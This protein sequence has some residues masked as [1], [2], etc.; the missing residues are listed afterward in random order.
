[1]YIKDALN[2][3]I[4]I[5]QLREVGAFDL[6]EMKQKSLVPYLFWFLYQMRTVRGSVRCAQLGLS[7]FQ[8]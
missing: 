6:L 8:F 7:K 3:A 1:M 5:T 2:N 4:L